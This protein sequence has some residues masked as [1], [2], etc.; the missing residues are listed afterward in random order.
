MGDTDAHG[1][2]TSVFHVSGGLRLTPMY[3]VAPT[4]AFIR[5]RH[6]GLSVAGKFAITEIAREHLVREARSWG[7]PERVARATIDRALEAIRTVGVPAA[8][9][10]FPGLREDVRAGALEQIA[11]VASS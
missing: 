6:V 3:D 9:E 11:R 10:L 4:L 7:M 5:Q 1:K 8:D 2:N